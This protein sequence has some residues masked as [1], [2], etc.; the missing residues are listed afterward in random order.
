LDAVLLVEG[1]DPVMVDSVQRVQIKA[2]VDDWLFASDG[3]GH[4][5]GLPR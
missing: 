3:Q 4:R 1:L 5:S 2:I